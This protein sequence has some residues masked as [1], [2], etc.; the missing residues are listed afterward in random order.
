M[1]R[2]LIALLV[3]LV[4]T[5]SAHAQIIVPDYGDTG[6]QTFTHTFTEAWSGEIG[7]AVSNYIDTIASPI[8]LID[9]LSFGT[10]GNQGFELGDFTGYGKAGDVSLVTSAQS[11]SSGVYT[12]TEGN[13]M[14]QLIPSGINTSMWGGTDGAYLWL[15]NPGSFEIGDTF[16]FD[17]AFLA[18]DGDPYYDFALMIHSEAGAYQGEVLAAIGEAPETIYNQDFS[19][20]SGAA[21]PEPAT[22]SLLGIGLLGLLGAKKKKTI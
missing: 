19:W 12:P 17:W 5:V 9:N 10:F 3:L 22:M 20:P 15:L 2:L 13:L 8:L 1:K 18:E 6:W 7:F 21:V 14:A 4:T 11:S 16:S